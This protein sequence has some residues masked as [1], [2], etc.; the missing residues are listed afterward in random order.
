MILLNYNNCVIK[1]TLKIVF[2]F[3]I[4][5][6]RVSDRR[7]KPINR[8]NSTS[9]I[10]D[11]PN[12]NNEMSAQN[13]DTVARPTDSCSNLFINSNQDS[14]NQNEPHPPSS[15]SQSSVN[16]TKFSTDISRFYIKKHST[17]KKYRW[18]KISGGS[19]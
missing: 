10:I 14:L 18:G 4:V 13:V 2:P 6:K 7:G 1:W 9:S 11:Q 19:I 3:G 16:I 17:S 5:S 8:F 12:R 15:N